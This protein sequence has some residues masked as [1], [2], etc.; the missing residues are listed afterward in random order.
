MVDDLVN[1][2]MS[3][4]SNFKKLFKFGSDDAQVKQKG[5]W[6]P[7]IKKDID[8]QQFW[9]IIGEIGEGAFGAVYKVGKECSFF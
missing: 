4:L 6:N 7:H 8:P 1:K 3:F 2:T 5:Q 9:E